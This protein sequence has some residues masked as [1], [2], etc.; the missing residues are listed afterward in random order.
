M[1]NTDRYLQ[2]HQARTRAQTSYEDLL[3]DALERAFGMGHYELPALVAYLN[4]SGPLSPS[5]K[6][7]TEESYQA[8]IGS[9]GQ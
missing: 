7:W 8:E 4:Q 1:S 3:G 5:G 9:L 2:P 6:P